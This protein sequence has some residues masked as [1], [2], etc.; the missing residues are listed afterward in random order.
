MVEEWVQQNEWINPDSEHYD[1]WL[2][3]QADLYAAQFN[4]RLIQA[5]LGDQVAS[6]DYFEI[7]DNHIAALR[8]SP[9]NPV[10]RH[11]QRRELNMKAPRGA[12]SGVRGGNDAS[13]AKQTYQISS[14]E[15]EIARRMGIDDKTY[16]KHRETIKADGHEQHK[17]RRRGE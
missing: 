10:N 8:A 4:Q 1:D 11:S 16:I 15:K 12:V 17:Y 6:P 13:Y 5:G 14:A 7:I 9:S 2:A 3:N